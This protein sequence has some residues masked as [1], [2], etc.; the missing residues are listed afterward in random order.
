M[1]KLTEK[2]LSQTSPEQIIRP[3]SVPSIE[4]IQHFLLELNH[5]EVSLENQRYQAGR[6]YIARISNS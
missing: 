4:W 6:Q 3:C 5:A 2:Q 1:T